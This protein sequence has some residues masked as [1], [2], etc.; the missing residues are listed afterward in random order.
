MP[1]LRAVGLPVKRLR[2]WLHLP[3]DAAIDQVDLDRV[4]GSLAAVVDVA[5][6]RDALSRSVAEAESARRADVAKTAVLHAISHDLRSPLTAITTAADAL[7]GP[8]LGPGDH[9]DLVGVVR[10]ESQRLA[11]LVD[12]LLDLS[13][14]QARA[15]NPQLDWCDLRDVVASAVAHVSVVCLSL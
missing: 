13:R 15:V 1:G 11:H 7:A 4:L 3:F 12:D 14:I 10:G 9:A 8:A 2:V 6:E 5:L